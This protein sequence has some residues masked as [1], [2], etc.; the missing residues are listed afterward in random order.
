MATGTPGTNPLASSGSLTETGGPTTLTL[1]A[2]ADGQ[3][4]VRSGTQL[5]GTASGGG[6]DTFVKATGTDT[7]A[8]VLSAKLPTGGDLTWTTNNPAGNETRTAVITNDKIVDAQINSSA[9]IALS[10]L[11]AQAALSVTANA[12]NASAVPT[13]VAAGT[14]KFVFRRSG[15]A[16]GWGLLDNTNIDPAAA[17]AYSQLANVTAK[18]LLGKAGAGN[19]AAAAITAATDG[20]IPVYDGTDIAFRQLRAGSAAGTQTDTFVLTL[21]SGV[22]T[23]LAS[24]G[25]GGG[26]T[27]GAA[28]RIPFGNA[29]ASALEDD[30][31][32]TWNKA[33]YTLFGQGG[34]SPYMTLNT[35]VGSTFGFGATNYVRVDGTDITAKINNGAFNLSGAAQSPN[36]V[37]NG[38]TCASLKG[39]ILLPTATAPSGNPSA[40]CA[41]YFDGTNVKLRVGATTTTFTTV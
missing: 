3:I 4:V 18:S 22:P 12:T 35:S 31:G 36:L 8:G 6:T 27:P 29:G 15:T 21:S 38:A 32:L 16:L 28:M 33:T 20:H 14:D 2:I 19:G 34:S 41:I 11:A 23:W 39:G 7:T 26:F 24:A 5:V 9:A 40:G 25:G 17:I 30:A 37:W 1:G 13:A 10:K